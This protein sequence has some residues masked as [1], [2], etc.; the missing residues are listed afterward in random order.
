VAIRKDAGLFPGPKH[1]VT[2]DPDYRGQ[3]HT[4]RVQVESVT[5]GDRVLLVDDWAELGSQAVAARELIEACGGVWAGAALVVDQ[6][7]HDRRRQL[8]PVSCIV[9]AD[10]LPPSD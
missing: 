2:A 8:A 3:R 5:A 6:L 7:P 4:L 10:E 9:F 1:S